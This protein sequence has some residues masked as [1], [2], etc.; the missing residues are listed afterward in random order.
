[1]ETP[2]FTGAPSGTRVSLA[3]Y[4]LWHS[5]TGSWRRRIWR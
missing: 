1:M 4:C 2:P 3:R 5:L